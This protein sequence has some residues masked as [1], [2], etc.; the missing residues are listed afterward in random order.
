[1]KDLEPTLKAQV[2]ELCQKGMEQADI[3][4][5][6]A[7]NRTCSKIFDLLPEPKAEW[8]AY[9]WLQA[10]RGDN[11]FELKDFQQAL[12]FFT[13]AIELDEAYQKNGFVWMRLGQCFYEL[14]QREKA[15]EEL[16]LAYS[17]GG[18]EIFEDEFAIYK[19]LA[20]SEAEEASKE[21]S[22]A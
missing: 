14:K 1:M 12:E 9:S 3:E 16:K 10:S 18:D 20:T 21:E 5:Y 6:E 22:G 7:S 4:R 17:L 13:E 8:K 11:F 2:V 19:K 15:V